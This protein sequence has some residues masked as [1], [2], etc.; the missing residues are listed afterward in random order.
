MDPDKITSSE[1]N[2]SR[3][4]VYALYLGS[5]GEGCTTSGDTSCCAVLIANYGKIHE[6]R[7]K[8]KSI[9]DHI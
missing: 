5:A 8:S 3:F 7:N 4:T 6:H 2:L 1:A 9:V